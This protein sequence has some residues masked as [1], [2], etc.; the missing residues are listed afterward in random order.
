MSTL[1]DSSCI[2]FLH[3]HIYLWNKHIHIDQSKSTHKQKTVWREIKE[4]QTTQ[5]R[6]YCV[7]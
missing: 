7:K 2:F 1:G 5:A 6:I 3:M 4:K